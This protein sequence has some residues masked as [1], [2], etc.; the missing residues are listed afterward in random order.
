MNEMETPCYVI[1]DTGF[2]TNVSYQD[3]WCYGASKFIGTIRHD[4]D[5]R[6]LIKQDIRENKE[7]NGIPVYHVSDHGNIFRVRA[8]RLRKI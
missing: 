8:I 4:E 1:S 5:A 3:D 6:E 7:R 2:K